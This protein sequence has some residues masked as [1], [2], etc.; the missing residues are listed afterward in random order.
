MRVKKFFGI[1]ASAL[2]GAG[3]G[4]AMLTACLFAAEYF[5]PTDPL[6]YVYLLR[7]DSGSRCTAFAT[8]DESVFTAAHCIGE[9]MVLVDR[10]GQEFPAVPVYVDTQ[11]DL[12]IIIAAGRP[13]GGLEWATGS[14]APENNSKASVIGFLGGISPIPV[15]QPVIVAFTAKIPHTEGSSHGIFTIGSPVWP[16][17][18][19][20]PLLNSD[21][22]VIGIAV[23]AHT[24]HFDGKDMIR[25]LGQFSTMLEFE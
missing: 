8:S 24:F 9:N 17:T 3:V 5:K 23:A 12:A 15:I 1:V 13:G 10:Y 16:G 2:V 6:D 14:T 22:E 7:N 21:N 4:L 18:S 25:D 11:G 20:G 19:G